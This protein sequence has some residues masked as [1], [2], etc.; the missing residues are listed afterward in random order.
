MGLRGD[1]C[2]QKTLPI[3]LQ[4]AET[5]ARLL[6]VEFGPGSRIDCNEIYN[7]EIRP[8][9]FALNPAAIFRPTGWADHFN[10]RSQNRKI[11]NII[12]VIKQP[13]AVWDCTGLPNIPKLSELLV[14]MEPETGWCV[15]DGDDPII[16]IPKEDSHNVIIRI[17]LD[18]DKPSTWSEV[19]TKEA[20]VWQ[21]PVNDCGY[22]FEI[23]DAIVRL[24]RFLPHLIVL[25]GGKVEF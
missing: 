2:R 4:E 18:W 14:A 5:V 16:S 7:P 23:S 17:S 24:N 8:L 6:D 22:N 21:E 13:Q 20:S 19:L 1:V 11:R 25:A 12:R 9:W 3:N 15:V 10:S